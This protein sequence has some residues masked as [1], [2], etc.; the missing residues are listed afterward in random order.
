MFSITVELPESL[1]VALGDTGKVTKVDVTAIAKHPEVLRFALINGF[2]GALNNISRGRGEDDKPNSDAVWASL[3][4][5][6]V[7]AWLAGEWAGRSGGG[8]RATTALKEAFIDERR[9]DT[10]ATIAQVEK[11]IKALVESTFGKDEPATFG[12]FMD[13]LALT[14][15]RRDIGDKATPEQVADYRTRIEAKYQ[16]LADDTRA[17]RDA[18]KAVLDVTSISL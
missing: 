18:A 14:M 5:K 16:K 13:A 17:K 7:N 12:R 4:E 15:A 3:R 1:E 10:G 11:S 2:M 6:R 8:E 9:A